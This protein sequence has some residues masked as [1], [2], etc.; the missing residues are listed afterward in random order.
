M[1]ESQRH[2]LR[3]WLSALNRRRLERRK[4]A[5]RNRETPSYEEWVR[6][7]S[8]PTAAQ[9]SAWRERSRQ[10]GQPLVS[11]LVPTYNPKPE[12]LQAAIASVMAQSHERWEL[13]L[14]DDASTDPQVRDLI[15]EL[16]AQDPRI[17]HVFRPKNGHISAAS[18]SALELATGDF[19]A[20]LDQD[21]L[22][23]PH[24][25]SLMVA[26]ALSHP[27][28]SLFYSD[29]DKVDDSG[30]RSQPHFKPDWNH[31]LALSQNYVCHLMMIR[32]DLV[33]EVGGFREGY[34]G[35]Q[36]H[37]LLLRCAERISPTQIK[38]VPHV[39][40][41]WRMHERSTSKSLGT[42][43]YAQLNGCKVVQEHL[44]RM[45]RSADVQPEGLFYKVSY[46]PPETWPTV[47][48]IV[49]TRDKPELL[50]KCVASI[51]AGTDYPCVELWIVDNGT[52]DPQARHW[53]REAALDPRVRVLEDSRPFNYSALNNLAVSKTRA[54]VLCLMNNDIEVTQPGWLK[55]MVLDLMQPCVGVVGARLFYPDG[56]LQ[57]AG[58]IVG[59][60]GTAGH[61]FRGQA[62]DDSHYMYR[63]MLPQEL[64]AVTAAC[65]LTRRETFDALDGLDERFAVAFNDIDYCLRA[66]EAG[67][68]VVYQPH[69]E[70]IHH[71]SA[72]RGKDRTKAQKDRLEQEQQLFLYRHAAHVGHDAAYNPNLSKK[73]EDASISAHPLPMSALESSTAAQSTA[74]SSKST[75]SNH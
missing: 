74:T 30:W 23:A 55:T 31:T 1:F 15:L 61:I 50:K 69:A 11:V 21:D 8:T 18:N 2:A 71:E 73:Y 6:R 45:H 17:K 64:S 32:A 12:H 14:A 10:R 48:V 4:F 65:M 62:R 56:T 68:K 66:K 54:D 42:K 75:A 53:L 38:H 40:Y 49:P 47:A 19:V 43:P 44:A 57:H 60:N 16:S 35:A 51:L 29:E 28:A 24:A 63:S 9:L 59:L 72:S 27:D 41:H 67:W 22:L 3:S 37:D 70:L 20:L 5:R 26:E 39:L 34:E 36:D 13:C 46:A 25:L 7:F 58:V 33:R 52:Q